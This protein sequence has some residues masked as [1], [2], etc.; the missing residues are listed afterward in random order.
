M[1]LC[2]VHALMVV[3]EAQDRTTAGGAVTGKVALQVF[4]SHVLVT[5]NVT[6][7]LPPAH[8]KPLTFVPLLVTEPGVHP[9]LADAD[10]RNDVHAALTDACDVQAESVVFDAQVRTTAD[11]AVT[12]KVAL[13]VLVSQVL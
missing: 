4:V 8:A 13:Q 12:A 10:A 7:L 11:G 5:V 2:D 9:P 6:V 1:S 3:F